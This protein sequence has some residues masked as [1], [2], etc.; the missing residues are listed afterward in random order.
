MND[1]PCACITGD[2]DFTNEFYSESDQK[3]RREHKCGECGITIKRGEVYSRAAGKTD[4]EMWHAKTCALCDEIRKH[5]YCD[6]GWLF[7]QLWE[8]IRE[9]LF[10]EDFRF[11]CMSGLSV[12]AREKMLHEWREW[13]GLEC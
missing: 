5:F 12:G 1:E 9:Q 3:A 8:D 6:G 13:K 4:G 10:D 7:T 11:E 2:D